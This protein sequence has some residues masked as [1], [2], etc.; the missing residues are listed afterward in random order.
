MEE[1]KGKQ[2]KVEAL[3]FILPTIQQKGGFA[4]AFTERMLYQLMGF[5]GDTARTMVPEYPEEVEARNQLELLN[6]NIDLEPITNID[7]EHDAYISIYRQA[8]NTPAKWKAIESR[9]LAKIEKAKQQR[10]STQSN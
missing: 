1:E 7:E 10:E 9:N 8:M 2:K 3:K 5:D 4:S 6:R